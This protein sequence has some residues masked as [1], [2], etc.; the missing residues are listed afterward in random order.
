MKA[1]RNYINIFIFYAYFSYD[2]RP[3]DMPMEQT[4]MT[5]D[6]MFSAS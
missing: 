1:E 5:I 6:I 2:T 3:K 4:T